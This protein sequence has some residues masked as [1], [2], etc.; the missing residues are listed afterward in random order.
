VHK[1]PI[2]LHPI[3]FKIISF[4]RHIKRW[5][6][7]DLVPTWL[8]GLFTVALF[9]TSYQ[10]ATIAS[11]QTDILK[12][13]DEA[14][15]A[16]AKTAEKLREITN[17]QA[18][19]SRQQLAEM[20]REGRAWVSIEPFLGHVTWDEGGV[21]VNITLTIKNTGK[22]PALYATRSARILSMIAQE[23]PYTILKRLTTEVRNSP[24]NVTGVPLFP[25][26]KL[27]WFAVFKYSRDDIRKDAT[28]LSTIGPPGH[29]EDKPN[30]RSE[31]L[32]AIG[33]TL[34]YFVDYT[35]GNDY[36]HHQHSCL[37]DIVKTRPGSAGAFL[38]PLDQDLAPPDVRLDSHP[39]NC[40][41][42]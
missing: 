18:E 7:S 15:N 27:D 41:A 20:E 22:I 17:A 21:N 42:D 8:T 24:I 30:R 10:L 12:H 34:I 1:I 16:S 4:L 23:H 11:R 29:P 19:I 31:D 38:L 3:P 39:I 13:T 36:A 14:M 26:D 6:T 2:R 37:A 33:L 25:G 40:A 32:H 28:Y 5:T 9:F 35:F